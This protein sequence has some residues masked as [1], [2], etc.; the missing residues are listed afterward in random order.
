MTVLLSGDMAEEFKTLSPYWNTV[1]LA[2]PYSI[3]GN[4]TLQAPSNSILSNYLQD[5]SEDSE[6]DTISD[7]LE[8]V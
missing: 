3:S 6:Q 5:A 7:R 1:D 4:I 8:Y 2:K